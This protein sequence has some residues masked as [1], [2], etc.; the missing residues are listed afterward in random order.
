M[1]CC[2]NAV[3]TK[4]SWHFLRLLLLLLLPLVVVYC[5]SQ[6][7]PHLRRRDLPRPGVQPCICPPRSLIIPV[8]RPCRTAPAMYPATRTGFH[9]RSIPAHSAPIP[10]SGARRPLGLF[11]CASSRQLAAAGQH[12]RDYGRRDRWIWE[13]R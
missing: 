3:H 8:V 5:S 9:S 2:Y 11:Y 6:H 10:F 7:Y 12:A 1:T 13:K 4:R